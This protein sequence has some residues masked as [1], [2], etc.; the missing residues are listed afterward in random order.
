MTEH[1]VAD[2]VVFGVAIG[3]AF[4]LIVLALWGVLS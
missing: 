1:E 3:T 2:G 4:W